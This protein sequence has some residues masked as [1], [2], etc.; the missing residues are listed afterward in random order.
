MKQSTK[1]IL[2]GLMAVFFSTS[3]YAAVI[4]V[5]QDG[6]G[7]TK[8]VQAAIMAAKNGD[9]I[10]IID[11]GVYI[12]DLM[13]GLGFQMTASFTLKADAGKTPIIQAANVTPRLAAFGIPG[14][15]YMGAAFLGCQNVLIEGIHFENLSTNAN[16]AGF[17][18]CL[19]I[20]DSVG[21]TVRNCTITGVWDTGVQFP[22]SQMN[23]GV[24]ILGIGLI[25]APKDIL[26][27]NCVINNNR[28]GMAIA[29]W[30]TSS[31]LA[32]PTVIIRNCKYSKCEWLC[33]E[34]S[35]STYPE[36]PDPK[37]TLTGPGILVENCSFTDSYVGII[38]DGGYLTTRN[39]SYSSVEY[40][41]YMQS[42]TIS[43]TSPV[44]GNIKDSNFIGCS[45]SGIGLYNDPSE[46]SVD[47]SKVV[48]NVDNCSFIGNGRHG[49]SLR[50]GEAH[51]T[52]SIFA[53]NGI[54]GAQ[55]SGETFSVAASFDHC[56]FYKNNQ[57]DDP[58]FMDKYEAV[59]FPE[60]NRAKTSFTNCN[61]TGVRG[62]R[63]GTGPDF[64]PYDPKACTVSYC[65]IFTSADQVTNLTSDNLFS[66]D[67][68]YISPVTEATLES[69]NEKGFT[70]GAAELLTKG[71]DGSYI[72]SQGGTGSGI[73]DW[74]LQQ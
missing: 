60:K 12:E 57:I 52:N 25:A 42:W 73:M 65:N 59:V 50:R 24:Y 74:E 37:T 49:V 1:T 43:G 63:N 45:R 61:F 18:G 16:M 69:Y 39:N 71:K 27:E 11:N 23:A 14:T 32:D 34:V 64:S 53:Y 47:N 30:P 4:R 13:A 6:S 20:A 62:I 8:S 44:V 54:A 38:H 9:D 41:I 7:D 67:P 15:D 36:S 46:T 29:E 72:G 28:K 66:I 35:D 17:C 70:V 19:T 55:I 31:S 68:K 22:D 2:F 21:I 10:L 5:A 3:V 26:L 33:L 58:D 51:F 56:D 48:A 40:G